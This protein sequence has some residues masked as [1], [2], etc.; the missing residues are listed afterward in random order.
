MV[1]TRTDL[2]WHRNPVGGLQGG[3]YSMYKTI[4]GQ[5]SEPWYEITWTEQ[6]KTYHFF[7]VNGEQTGMREYELEVVELP[8]F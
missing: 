2:T 7:D 4:D 3:D 6:V 8:S 5:P 1:T